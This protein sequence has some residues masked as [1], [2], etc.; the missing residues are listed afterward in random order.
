MADLKIPPSID[1]V[2]SQW[3]T[4]ALRSNGVINVSAVTSLDSELIGA[5]QGFT[6]L[7]ARLT[8]TYDSPEPRAP[9]SMFV[10]VP[11]SDTSV[12]IV[13]NEGG[14]FEREVRFYG[15]SRLKL[16]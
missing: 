10:K 12:R 5:G 15:S 7:P 13:P 14:L 9:Q 11:A 6:G 4:A 8:P 1:Y 2:T 3:L 16:S